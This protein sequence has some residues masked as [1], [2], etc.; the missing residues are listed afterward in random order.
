MDDCGICGKPFDLD[1]EDALVAEH[2][3]C[4]LTAE[5][6]IALLGLAS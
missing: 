1:D 5:E 3:D 4:A 6:L 2:V